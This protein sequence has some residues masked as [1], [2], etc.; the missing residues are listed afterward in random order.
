MDSAGRGIVLIIKVCPLVD[1][2]YVVVMLV[3]IYA[4]PAKES[5]NLHCNS[6]CF[7]AIAGNHEHE[8][9]VGPLACKIP[10]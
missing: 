9:Q 5:F 4:V 8:D 10:G 1:P 2:W 3:L 7:R 6:A